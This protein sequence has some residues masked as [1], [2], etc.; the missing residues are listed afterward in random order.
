MKKNTLSLILVSLL[1][2]F[3]FLQPAQAV[4]PPPDGG[5]PNGNTAEGQAALFSLNTGGYNTAVGYLSL[6]SDLTGQ[7]NTAVGAGALVF[8]TADSNTAVGAG[9][10]LLNGTGDSNTA[11]GTFALTNNTNGI[12]NTAVGQGALQS[13]QGGG[14]N[15]AVGCL[16]L[17]NSITTSNTAVGFQALSNT[18]LG[19]G[20]TA[21]GWNAGL[22]ITGTANICIGAGVHGIA[23]DN[24]TIRVGD[25]LP[26]G[27]GQSACYIGGIDGQ[28]IDPA[29]AL[30][31]GIDATGKLGTTAS[32][33][34][35]KRGIKPIDKA[36]EAILALK[37]VTFHYK[38]DAKNTSCFGL[39]AEKWQR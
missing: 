31:V 7:L 13:D 12:R 35:F 25:N 22:N 24:Y 39:I 23:G 18:S 38:G 14:D 33:Q 8:N 29:T 1:T 36:S 10:L 20:D 27:Q 6:A 28:T 32:S 16:A 4:S 37:P 34:R 30:P 11:I 2:C 3:A 17:F 15:T 26:T 19:G 9:A 5:Y 21:V